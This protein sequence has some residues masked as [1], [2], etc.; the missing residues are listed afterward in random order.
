[1]QRNRPAWQRPVGRDQPSALPAWIQ[2][3]S[4]ALAGS[5]GSFDLL[6]DLPDLSN[7]SPGQPGQNSQRLQAFSGVQTEARQ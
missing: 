4:I 6:D 1:M 7:L 5:S 3:Q 2:G